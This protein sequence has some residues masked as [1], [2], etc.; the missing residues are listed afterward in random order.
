MVFKTR[1]FISYK[2]KLFINNKSFVNMTDKDDECKNIINILKR[3][4]LTLFFTIW[5]HQP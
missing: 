2:E 4:N 1:R 3:Y 5:K